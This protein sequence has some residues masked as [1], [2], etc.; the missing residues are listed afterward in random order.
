MLQ[1]KFSKL[2]VLCLMALIPEA[3]ASGN[4]PIRD[5]VSP[6]MSPTIHQAIPSQ[7]RLGLQNLITTPF[8]F[9]INVSSTF[10]PASIFAKGAVDPQNRETEA[11]AHTYFLGGISASASTFTIGNQ[12]WYRTS[13][14]GGGYQKGILPIHIPRSIPWHKILP[15]LTNIEEIS[16]AEV[17]GEEAIAYRFKISQPGLGF[18]A[19]EDSSLP[20]GTIQSAHG[21]I[22]FRKLKPYLPIAAVLKESVSAEGL[23]YPLLEIIHY[24][25]WGD[26]IFLNPSS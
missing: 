16:G 20:I 4:M 3:F 7:L 13:P 5:D 21:I 23:R 6:S 8:H 10:Y 26:P 25:D 14:P 24:R 9:Q 12:A 22:Y 19:R 1:S 15:Y 18:I 2:A 11:T 17:D